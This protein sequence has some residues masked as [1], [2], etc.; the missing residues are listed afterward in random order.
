MKMN[1]FLVGGVFGAAAIGC[2]LG[3]ASAAPFVSGSTGADGAFA[4]Q[5]TTDVQ[6]PESGIFNV[7]TVN[8]PTGVTVTFRKNST[9]TPVTILAT[10]DVVINGTIDV[11]GANGASVVDGLSADD[12]L[13]GVGGPGG[14]NGGFGANKAV[15][16]SAGGGGLGPGA[17]APGAGYFSGTTSYA[18][19]G[20]GAGFATAGTDGPGTSGS[21]GLAYGAASLLPLN[22]GSGG[23]GGAS[24]ATYNGS[25]GGGGGGAIL[26]ASSGSIQING[27]VRA[28][29]G[30]GGNAY[31]QCSGEP[32]FGGAGSGGAIRLL[33][34]AVTGSGSLSAAG[35][36]GQTAVQY[37][38]GA[39]S[40]CV[41]M[42]SGK[43]GDGRIRV[44]AYTITLTGTASPTVV[45]TFVPGQVTIP[46][47]PTLSIASVGGVAAPALPTGASDVALPFNIT[48]PVEVVLSATG[49]PVGTVVKVTVTPYTG[50]V[51]G[52]TSSPLAG[53]TSSSSATASITLGGGH[54]VV[55]AAAT[56]TVTQ[57]AAMGIAVPEF[58]AG[59][60]VE[61]VRLAANYGGH[62]TW[63][64]VTRGGR[65]VPWNIR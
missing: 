64:A 47:L 23:G 29:G 50:A 36:A 17:G 15:P 56:F 19:G 31:R 27:A 41:V 20:G 21:K 54:S 3:Y 48:N 44:E 34:N 4:P 14:G 6:L 16:G 22:G 39:Y 8:I 7:T 18:T 33:A 30:T 11:S 37:N 2:S 45:A 13:P 10:G 65:E 60:P 25:G 61:S 42:T 28:N 62:A 32:G 46:S 43:G 9:N 55:A 57:A 49:I 52:V 24:T 53:T 58:Y 5:A 40:P 59:E 51:A 26:I 38:S 12:T 35:G 1:P 63:F